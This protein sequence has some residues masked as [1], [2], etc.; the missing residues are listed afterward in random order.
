M[1]LFGLKHEEERKHVLRSRHTEEHKHIEKYDIACVQHCAAKADD[2]AYKTDGGKDSADVYLTAGSAGLLDESLC[3]FACDNSKNKTYYGN[4]KC[5][6]QNTEYQN[7][8]RR[9]C[10]DGSGFKIVVVHD[11][12]ILQK[13]FYRLKRTGRR[14]SV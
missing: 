2:I 11:K 13:N 12:Y 4:G 7:A 5:D 6:G 9:N 1:L 8:G 10:L 3:L 14:K